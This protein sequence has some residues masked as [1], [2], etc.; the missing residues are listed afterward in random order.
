MKKLIL[1]LTSIVCLA[2]ASVSCTQVASGT[3]TYKVGPEQG[4]PNVLSASFQLSG[5]E[6]KLFESLKEIGAVFSPEDFTL[7]LTGIKKDCDKI[8]VSTVDRTMT[9]IENEE[10]Y[11]VLSD[12]SG[13]TIV[14]TTDSNEKGLIDGEVHEIYRREF[15]DML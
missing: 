2:I 6:N 15:R 9:E 5:C 8:I 3:F 4:S 12:F 7:S 10:V 1:T 13:L 14:V 11:G